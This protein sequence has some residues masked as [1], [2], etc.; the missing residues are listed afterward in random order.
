MEVQINSLKCAIGA[1]TLSLVVTG[2]AA[3]LQG[4]PP[5]NQVLKQTTD[6]PMPGPAVRFDYQSKIPPNWDGM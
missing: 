3:P 1:L 6:I 5:E 2:S 4:Q